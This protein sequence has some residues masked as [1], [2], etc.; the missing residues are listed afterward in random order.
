MH[1]PASAPRPA[2]GLRLRARLRALYHGSSPAAVRFR[3]SVIVVDFAIIAFFV[4][5]PLL[6]ENGYVFYAL[7]ALVALIL[8]ADIAGRALACPEIKL[9]LRRPI[10]WIDLFILATLL[11]PEWLFNLGFL[12]VLRL[13]TLI[14]SDFFWDTVGRRYDDTRV[15]ETTKALAA[16][17]TFVFVATGFVYTSFIGT[18]EG[19]NGYLDALYFTITSLTT[20]GYGDILLPGPWGRIVSIVIMLMGVT[21]FVRLGQTLIRPHKVRHP[22]PVCGLQ[23]HD[24][25]AVHC[26]A[27]GT[28]LCIP[29]EGR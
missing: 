15:E 18:H 2:R 25:D 14:N 17:V 3:Y 8:A 13:W 12:R 28:T 10:V 20:T 1:A 22:C 26:K 11:F 9:Y 4:A 19:L 29:D 16:L 24:P 6:K 21:L 7:D 27:C 5:A 23:R